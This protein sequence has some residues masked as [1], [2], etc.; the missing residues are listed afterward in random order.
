MAKFDYV[1]AETIDDAV[2]TVKRTGY[3]QYPSG[4][5]YRYLCRTHELTH[6]GLTGW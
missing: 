1:I 4:R 2:R 6:S 3:S 5:W